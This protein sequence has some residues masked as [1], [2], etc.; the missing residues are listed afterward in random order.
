MSFPGLMSVAAAMVRPMRRTGVLVAVSVTLLGSTACGGSDEGS[1]ASPATVTASHGASQEPAPTDLSVSSS[2][3]PG[4]V[5]TPSPFPKGYPKKVA[6]SSLPDQVR[7]WYQM[8]GGSKF[9]V[10][11]APGVW[12]ELSPGATVADAVA[13][14]VYDGFCGSIKAYERRYTHGQQHPGTCW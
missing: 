12:A 9:A 2:P 4:P 5:R 14:G 11:I 13:A 10:A 6:V 7:S 8:G 3:S 1:A